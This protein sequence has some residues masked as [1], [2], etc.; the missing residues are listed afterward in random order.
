[1]A[2][3]ARWGQGISGI[4]PAESLLNNCLIIT[5]LFLVT[6]VPL[7]ASIPVRQH[8]QSSASVVGILR[9]ASV[10]WGGQTG[11]LLYTCTCTSIMYSFAHCG[12]LQLQVW[13]WDGSVWVDEGW[14]GACCMR[15][16]PLLRLLL[17]VQSCS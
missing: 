8:T 12:S 1:M 10:S 17:N 15:Q 5:I 6:T 11:C 13:R 14:V 2:C 9:Y 3:L 4:L 7:E 16:G